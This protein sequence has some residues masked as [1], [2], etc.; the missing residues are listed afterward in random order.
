M[1][2]AFESLRREV[3]DIPWTSAAVFMTELRQVERTPVMTKQAS[4][5]LLKLARMRKR[6]QSPAD[7][8]EMQRRALMTDPSIV[9]ALDQQQAAVENQVLGEQLERMQVE[10]QELQAQ[11]AAAETAAIQAQQQNQMLQQELQAAHQARQAATAQ[12]LQAQDA[13]LSEQVNQQQHRQQVMEAA[14]QLALQLK[15]VAATSPAEQ[16]AMAQAA[17]GGPATAGGEQPA[18][19]EGQPQAAYAKTQ[20]QIEEAQRAEQNAAMQAQDAEKAVVEEQSKLAPVGPMPGGPVPAELPPKTSSLRVARAKQQLRQAMQKRAQIGEV[21]SLGPAALRLLGYGGAGAALGAGREGI[22][23]LH[24]A[25]RGRRALSDR[26]TELMGKLREAELNAERTPTYKN[27]LRVVGLRHQ[28][29]KAQLSREHPV[30]ALASAAGKGF[31]AGV[32][33]GPFIGQLA[34]KGME[35]VRAQ[36]ALA[37][38][39]AEAAARVVKGVR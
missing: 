21:T 14:D 15:Q 4:I 3:H 1:S 31:G 32:A 24:Y 11:M 30:G 12:A 35:A 16:Q 34:G 17:V 37:D 38:P 2:D 19:L 29:G 13:A 22:R 23:Q 10:S 27:K 6:A 33:I 25:K 9:A 20:K 36:R 39:A 26:E 18:P 7:L 5:G 8:E 28:L